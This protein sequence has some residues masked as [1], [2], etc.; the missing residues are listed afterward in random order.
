[1]ASVT[2]RALAV[3]S[4]FEVAAG[5][6]A[7]TAERVPSLSLS[8]IARRAGL[9]LT[10][11]HRLVHELEAWQALERQPGGDYVVGRRLWQVGLLAPVQ[12][13]LRDVARPFLQDLYE[14]TRENVHLAVRDGLS[15]LYVELV[16][17][18]GSVPV[19]SRPG[20]RLPLHATGVGK[21]LL[22]HAPAEVRDRAT[23]D[24]ARVTRYTVV[25]PG[26]LRRELADT[27]RRG[28]ARTV[29][30]MTLGTWSV[31]VPVLGADGE[32]AAALGLVTRTQR[33]DLPRLAPAL[34][35]AAAGITRVLSGPV[36]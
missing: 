34:Q 17:G 1:M 33:R 23:A 15:A 10:T 6:Q 27:R 18:R 11:A 8:A 3:L 25:E 35:V 13:E 4:A 28:W 14:T 20:A 22:A 19:E 32:V 29:E 24:P 9:P 7:A 12:R 21:V 31:A 5:E 2:G 26:R 30:E 16:S 36:P